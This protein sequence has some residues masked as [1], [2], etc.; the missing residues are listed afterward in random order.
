MARCWSLIDPRASPPPLTSPRAHHTLCCTAIAHPSREHR[1]HPFRPSYAAAPRLRAQVRGYSRR[2]KIPNPSSRSKTLLRIVGRG[3][4]RRSFGSARLGA[5]RCSVLG[6][7]SPLL[8]TTRFAAKSRISP[9]D[10]PLRTIS[11]A[12]EKQPPPKKLE[13]SSANHN[14][15]SWELS[16]SSS[17]RANN[18]SIDLH[19]SC[20]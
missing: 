4:I 19:I 6:W 11:F 14:S 1:A 16:T 20:H 18:N 2:A 13:Q 10:Q 8:L 3:T 12:P 15:T 9:R 7:S 17:C 5:W